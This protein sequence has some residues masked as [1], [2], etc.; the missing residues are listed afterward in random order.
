MIRVALVGACGVAGAYRQGYPKIE[1]VQWKVAVDLDGERVK[2]CLAEGC[3]RVSTKLEDALA[4]D[5]DVVD[6]WTPNFLHEEQA[7]RALEAGKHVM[8]Q[9][10]IT[11]TLEGADH[12]FGSE[13]DEEHGG[14]VHD[15]L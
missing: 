4:D 12:I 14:G 5:V 11:H 7:V 1:G 3:E 9:K 6:I 15:V 13:E 8:L 10:S 2:K